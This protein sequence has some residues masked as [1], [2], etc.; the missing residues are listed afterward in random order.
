M[1]IKNRQELATS[2][3]R[4]NALDIIEAGIERV[5]PSAIVQASVSF[6]PV[7]KTLYINEYT[8]RVNG[9]IFVI[10][11]GKA[12]GLMAQALEEIVGPENIE[13]GIV[14]DKAA[15][16]EFRTQKI[17][18]MQAGHPLPD[19]RGIKAVRAMLD[20][21][22]KYSICKDDLVICLISGGGSALMPYPADGLSL[23]DKQKV[24]GLLLSCGAN[25][26]EINTV[27]KH[28]SGIKG[29]RLAQYFSPASVLSLILSDVVG[30][31]MSIIASG[32]ICPDSS[33]Y[34]DARLV[35][36]KYDLLHKV[37]G[38]ILSVLEQGCRGKMEETP[39]SLENIQNYIIGDNRLA[40]EAMAEKASCSGFK[41]FIV[42]AEQ[43][44]DTAVA[45]RQRAQEILDGLYKPYDAIIMS[46]ETTPVLPDNHGTGGRN[47][48]YAALTM[49]LLENYPG[50]WLLAS[51]ATDG[52]DYL[53]YV[54]GAIVDRSSLTN[55]KKKN[56]DIK[57]H[58]ERYDS[59]TLLRKT[60]NSIILTGSTGTNVGDVMLY[61]LPSSVKT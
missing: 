20:L 60:G 39:K 33:T 57:A 3:L 52:S 40:L 34:A 30:N 36:G 27:R 42:T 43:T 38:N 37:P 45:A 8:C 15:P 2:K 51:V 16:A 17:K 9:R 4:E 5:L 13:A 47:Q 41:P 22:A 32:L 7:T 21:K 19:E 48:H 35:L 6:D 61:L 44:G 25:I 10:G 18:V 11:G 28:L 59:Y 50:E 46:G 12:S 24:T 23:G 26:H 55:L 56:V 29:G 49:L 54:A 1:I 58:L 14:I 53:P 31:D